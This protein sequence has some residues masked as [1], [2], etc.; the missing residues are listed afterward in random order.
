[1]KKKYYIKYK[2]NI[3]LVDLSKYVPAMY[4]S[5]AKYMI[6]RLLVII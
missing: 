2:R 3:T 4:K 5:N 6:M 1:M